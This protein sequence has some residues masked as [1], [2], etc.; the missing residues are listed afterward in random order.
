MF[1]CHSP[2][3]MSGE[4]CIAPWTRVTRTDKVQMFVEDRRMMNDVVQFLR[5]LD[6]VTS[7]SSTDFPFILYMNDNKLSGWSSAKVRSTKDALMAQYLLIPD[8][9]SEKF[10][11]DYTRARAV[12][13]ILITSEDTNKF[14]LK[15]PKGDIS[16]LLEER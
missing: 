3:Q 11:K 13:Q 9:L 2:E 8:I 1:D 5:Q 10:K 4:Q 14:I 15:V 16:K 7:V 12:K 6:V